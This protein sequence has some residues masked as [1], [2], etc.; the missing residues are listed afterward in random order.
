MDIYEGPVLPHGGG[1]KGAVFYYVTKYP[2]ELLVVHKI[3]LGYGLGCS[4]RRHS[5]LLRGG[6]LLLGIGRVK[7]II[8]EP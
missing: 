1:T 7:D 5:T 8:Y 3:Y 2:Y 4:V 6:L